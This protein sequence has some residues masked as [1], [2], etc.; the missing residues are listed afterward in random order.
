MDVGGALR[1]AREQRGLSLDQLSRATKIR[2]TILEAIET[3]RRE[4]LPETIFLRGFVRAYAR[5]VGLNPE[6]TV[7]GYLGQ[8]EPV[9]DIIE[10]AK[11]GTDEARAEHHPVVRGEI[12]Q[13]EAERRPMRVQW[14]LGTVVLIMGFAGYYT[15]A[16]WRA[17]AP[18]AT[19]SVSRPAASSEIARSSSPAAPSMAARVI[20]PETTTPGSGAPTPAVAPEGDLLHLAIHSPAVDNRC[21]HRGGPPSDGIVAGHAVVCPLH[22]WKV[23][24]ETGAVERPA[25]ATAC[26]RTYATR[27][28]AGLIEWPLQADR[29]V[30][31]TV[32]TTND[33]GQAA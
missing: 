22:A 31:T 7:R 10:V 2:I 6:D 18:R 15:V 19:L 24:L 12:D 16:W 20:R 26:L 32:S 3:N 27:V 29:D 1:D 30:R 14:L 8:F 4:K 5:E 23:C 11:S 28:E 17:S 33:E 21:P 25:N 9:I 13:D